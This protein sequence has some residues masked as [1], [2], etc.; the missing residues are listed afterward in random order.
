MMPTQDDALKRTKRMLAEFLQVESRD[1]QEKDDSQIQIQQSKFRPDMVLLFGDVVFIVEYKESGRAASVEN[2]IQQLKRMS[3][4]EKIPIRLLV[5]PYMHNLG[6]ERSRQEGIS[7]LDLSGNADISGPGIRI[8]ISG[9]PN[10]YRLPGRSSGVFARKS[11]RVSRV[12]LYHSKSAFTQRD[13]ARMTDLDEGYVSKIVRS[14]EN[15]ELIDRLEDGSVMARDKFLL[16]D[17]WREA[18]DFHK[19]PLI[20]GHVPARS[21]LD[22]LRMASRMLSSS[23]FEHAASGLAGAWLYTQFADFRIVTIYL[24]RAVSTD[25][26]SELNFRE[27]ELGENIWLVKPKDDWALYESREIDGVPC[28]HPV[29][30]F[31]DLK[32]H[33]E[34]SEEA[35]DELRKVIFRPESS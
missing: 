16:L 13:I 21:G 12:L 32:G 10:I 29:Q 28:A 1:I 2:G 17:A 5:V 35:A 33:P 9:R 26:L 30:V 25:V 4:Q 22:L 19:Q 27:G 34:R 8:S 3:H 11:S 7:W 18:Y 6:R 15:D 24:R 31:L 20:R 23:G 14:L